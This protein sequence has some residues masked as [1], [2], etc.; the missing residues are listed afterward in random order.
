MRFYY[1]RSFLKLLAVGFTLVALPLVFALVNNAI[2]IDRLANRSQQ[3]VYQAVQA[4]QSSR[5][6]VELLTAMERSARQM[7]ILGDPAL[8]DTYALNRKQFLATAGEFGTLPFDSEQKQALDAIVRDEAAIYAVL[9]G[10]S[11]DPAQQAKAVEGFIGLADRAQAITVRSNE[12]IDR[13]VE[14]MRATAAQAQRIML[15][16]LLALIPVVLFLAIGFTI[17]IARPIRQIDSAI[18]RLGGGELNTAVEVAGPEDLQYLGQRLEWMRRRLVDLDQQKNRF[19]RQM[20]HELKTPLTALREG[21]ELLSDE[22]VGKLSPEQREIAEILRYNSIELQKLIDDLLSYG[23]SQFH[24]TA[25][26]LKPVEVRHIIN[27][28]ADDHRLALR[29]KGVKLDIEARDVT[30]AAD[31]EKLRIILDNLMSNAIKFSPPGGTVSIA[32]RANG[33]HLELDVADEGP[34]IAPADRPHI[35][36][37]FYQGAQVAE[38]RVKGTGIGLSVVREYATAH[39]GSVEVVDEAGRRGA[40]LRVRLPLLAAGAGK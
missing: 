24:K 26:E 14:A 15:W 21:A 12:L 37:P 1:P 22:V 16:Q 11:A 34:G 32:A 39:G 2:S 28:V 19:L 30:L 23:A 18:R 20:S 31:F 27:R 10:A 36:D 29:A 6:L 3:A 13:E 40:R 9:S 35:F 8:L 25:L 17:L 38:G 7:V 4:T 33:A 5:R